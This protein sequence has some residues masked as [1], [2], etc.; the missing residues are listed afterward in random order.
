V[1][2]LRLLS[3][4]LLEVVVLLLLL[5]LCHADFGWSGSVPCCCCCPACRKAQLQQ[6]AIRPCVPLLLH[7]ITK[8]DLL[9]LS[10]LEDV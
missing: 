2:G 5:L 1:L 6:H 8:G 7:A 10:H 4:L 9:H 3:V